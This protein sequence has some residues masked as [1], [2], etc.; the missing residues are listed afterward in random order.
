MSKQWGTHQF[1]MPDR[2]Y[3]PDPMIEWGQ[4]VGIDPKAIPAGGDFPIFWDV[5][6]SQFEYSE[7]EDPTISPDTPGQVIRR[8]RIRVDIPPPLE[9]FIPL[10]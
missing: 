1:V 7:L 9:N 4:K 2:G 10:H 5:D 6:T 8:K 3:D